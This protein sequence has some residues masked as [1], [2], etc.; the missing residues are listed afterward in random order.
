M[1]SMLYGAKLVYFSYF[2]RMSRKNIAYLAVLAILVIVMALTCNREPVSEAEE[3]EIEEMEFELGFSDDMADEA[4]IIPESARKVYY[5]GKKLPYAS[6]F[7]DINDLHIEAA[8]AV[9][10]SSPVEKRNKINAARM[11]L[12]QIF[13]TPSFVVANLTHSVPYLTKGASEELSRI[14][15]AFCA[16]LSSNGLPAYRLVVNSVLRTQEDVARLRRSGNVNATENSAHSYGTTFDI[17]YTKFRK[18]DD[19]DE[20]M[21]PY[22]LTKVLGEV[23]RDERDAGRCYVK[24]E[25]K[26]H[27][28]HITSRVK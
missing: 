11:G 23:L 22:E 1:K 18:S 27:C 14:A 2:W 9:G 20:V 8:K 4:E 15:D 21:D 26:Q 3:R 12:V 5:S 6:L 17:S 7:S 28:F 13:E 19:S 16:K 10:L 25:K 24:Y